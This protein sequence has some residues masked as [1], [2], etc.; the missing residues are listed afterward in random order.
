MH[1]KEWKGLYAK[2]YKSFKEN[3][4]TAEEKEIQNS[5]GGNCSINCR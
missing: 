2:E 1:L 3:R 4:S 5:C